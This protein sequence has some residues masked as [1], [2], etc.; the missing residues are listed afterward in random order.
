MAMRT[1]G[2]MLLAAALVTVGACKDKASTSTD[3]GEAKP[4]AE[5]AGKPAKTED[6]P[7][8]AKAEALAFVER[9]VAAQKALDFPAYIA[10]YEPR[11]FRG[12]KRTSGGKVTEFDLAGWQTDRKRMF[13]RK[14]EI[15]VEPLGVETWL[16]QG[17]KLKRG[18]SIVRFTQRWRGGTYADHGVKVL[19]V[20]RAAEGKL[21]IT[22][23]DL[24]N[25]ERGWD[26]KE[27][28][29]GV[30]TVD[31]PVPKTPEDALALWKKLAPT[32][33]DYPAKLASIPDDEAVRGPMALAL[34]AGG[35]FECTEV[36]EYEECGQERVEWKDLDPKWDFDNPCLR[37]RLVE[38]ALDEIQGK[39]VDKVGAQ[40]VAMAKLKLP[41]D[42]LP[43]AV[44]LEV[45]TNSD[46]SEALRLDVYG[47]LT[48]SERED[49]VDVSG[50]SEEGL[51]TAA[52]NHG[53]DAAAVKLHEVRHMNELAELLNTG[54]MSDETR[55]Q[56]LERLSSI[57]EPVVTAAIAKLTGDENCSLAMEAAEILAQR[58]DQ[59][60]LPRQRKGMS[61]D[62]AE[63]VI[64]M[65]M[66]D[67]DSTRGDTRLAEFIH[68][69][70]VTVTEE[71]QDPW[72]ADAGPDD[73]AEEKEEPLRALDDV[74]PRIEPVLDDTGGWERAEMHM[75]SGPDGQVYISSFD[76]YR[77]NGCGC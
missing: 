4:R 38:W 50:L 48:E 55:G 19:H 54:A 46:V 20:W 15:A 11:T 30:A 45:S 68:P 10:L 28:A 29:A 2:S 23:E 53:I 18:M 77:Y 14:F 49:L 27:E 36:V 76:F 72:E 41:E 66:K 42:E 9:W 60:Y 71:I 75:T 21:L 58:G 70:G 17:S 52:V 73:P 3:K 32:G 39:D 31:L 24:L 65:L 40:L 56:I 63:H 7:A 51:V 64:C 13:D 67:S 62:E 12:V 25:S 22:Y 57:K 74:K 6:K 43:Q 69:D 34:L 26:R 5:A 35:Q 59:S 37:R 16:D 61:A 1:I 47:A 33:A 8:A 44:N